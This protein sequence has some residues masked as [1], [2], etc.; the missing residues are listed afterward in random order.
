MKEICRLFV[1]SPNGGF[2]LL[3]C[4]FRE[5]ETY[6]TGMRDGIVLH[7]AGIPQAREDCIK[8]GIVHSSYRESEKSGGERSLSTSEAS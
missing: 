3:G 8:V 5:I 6:V 2:H 4:D 7:L 1:A